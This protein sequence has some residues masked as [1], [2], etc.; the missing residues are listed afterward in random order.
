M[1]GGQRPLVRVERRFCAAKSS[2][3]AAG[4][5]DDTVRERL[6]GQGACQPLLPDMPQTLDMGERELPN[7]DTVEMPSLTAVTDSRPCQFASGDVAITRLPLRPPTVVR[8]EKRPSVA[9]ACVQMRFCAF[10]PAMMCTFRAPDG[11]STF[12]SQK[13]DRRRAA[14]FSSLAACDLYLSSLAALMSRRSTLLAAIVCS[15]SS[16][17]SRPSMVTDAWIFSSTTRGRSELMPFLVMNEKRK[18]FIPISR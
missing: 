18:V 2:A 3:N 8:N 14:A 11:S 6:P 12:D 16:S 17:F 1:Q 9:H 13:V 5:F 15:G 7:R 10:R 4:T